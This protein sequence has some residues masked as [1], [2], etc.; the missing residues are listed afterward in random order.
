MYR[1]A[2][3]NPTPWSDISVL[4]AMVEI[5]GSQLYQ[6]LMLLDRQKNAEE[7]A[8]QKTVSSALRSSA[9]PYLP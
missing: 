2:C 9:T 8:I 1:A 6:N 7:A 5:R 3:Q 4:S